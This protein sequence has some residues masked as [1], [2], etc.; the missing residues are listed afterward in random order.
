[1]DELIVYLA[2][3]LLGPDARPLL[4]LPLIESL[5]DGIQ[6]DLHST[7]RMGPDLKLVLRPQRRDPNL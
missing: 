2:P 1:M 4:R 6:F 3:K 7:E 5:D